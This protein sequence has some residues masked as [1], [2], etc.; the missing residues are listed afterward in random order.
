MECYADEKGDASRGSLL[1]FFMAEDNRETD[2]Y[3]ITSNSV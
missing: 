3:V 2:I 1:S